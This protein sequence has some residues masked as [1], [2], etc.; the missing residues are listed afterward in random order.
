MKNIKRYLRIY[1]QLF[2][3]NVMSEMEYRSNFVTACVAQLT[4]CIIK[5]L[6]ALVIYKT[7]VRIAGFTPDEI[8]IFIGTYSALSGVFVSF[9]LMNFGSLSDYI[10]TAELDAF[11]TKPVSLQFY[12]SVRKVSLPYAIVTLLVGGAM[13]AIGW[14]RAGVPFNIFNLL[15]F[16][17]LTMC[18]LFVTYSLFLI[19][20]ILGFWLVST[21]GL[22][23]FTNRLWDFNNMP[24]IIY[25]RI[26]Q[27]I[28][29]FVIPVF[30]ITNIG[31]LFVLGRLNPALL[32][33]SVV[34]PLLLF[35]ICCKFF[36]F[37]LRYYTSASN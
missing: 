4:Y 15:G 33:W 1:L 31:P 28:G 17:G 36:K 32:V 6:Y 34:S 30:L 26:I 10:R 7:N 8:L 37:A 14:I 13:I 11:I 27:I 18:G 3:M 29:L 22:A 9:F 2:K 20:Q 23:L 5:L 16:I 19:P 24:M 21:Q 25:N 35:W 12:I